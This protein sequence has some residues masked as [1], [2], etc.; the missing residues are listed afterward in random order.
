MNQLILP[1]IDTALVQAGYTNQLA[2]HY[3]TFGTHLEWE[4]HHA[5]RAEYDDLP[6]VQDV[7]ERYFLQGTDGTLFEYFPREH[8]AR[9]VKGSDAADIAR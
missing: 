5:V 2:S 7:E 6:P 1:G 9:A 3:V 8:T 4:G